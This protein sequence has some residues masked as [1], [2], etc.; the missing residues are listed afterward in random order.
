MKPYSMAVKA[1]ILDGSGRCLLLRRS[2]DSRN[3]PGRWEWPGGKVDPGE[4]FVSAL[5]RETREETGL[6]IE[7]TGLAGATTFEMPK[8]KVV[9]L[10]ME[11]R[12]AG[13]EVRLSSEHDA[14]EWVP[15]KELS[16]RPQPNAIQSFVLAYAHR[17]TGAA[18]P[19]T[20]AEV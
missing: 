15:L 13:G 10:S 20:R 19:R 18:P 14:W 6:E 1:V 7:I 16:H 3:F 12:P 5:V 2:A 11:A 4:D 8:V 9:L 17:K